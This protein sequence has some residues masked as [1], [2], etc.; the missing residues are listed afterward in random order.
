MVTAKLAI[1]PGR[2]WVVPQSWRVVSAVWR[3]FRVLSRAFAAV[4]VAACAA[5]ATARTDDD[6]L[7]SDAVVRALGDALVSWSARPEARDGLD[8]RYRMT[9]EHATVVGLL[10]GIRGVG[11]ERLELRLGAVEVLTGTGAPGKFDSSIAEL[12]TSG[13]L[14]GV[15]ADRAWT[16]SVDGKDV[17]KAAAD[18][19]SACAPSWSVPAPVPDPTRMPAVRSGGF[20][21]ELEVTETGSKPLAWHR[22]AAESFRLARRACAPDAPA[23]DRDAAKARV[24]P[25]LPL[26]PAGGMALVAWVERAD[27]NQSL[28][29]ASGRI[30]EA[31]AAVASLRGVLERAKLPTL[32]V[33]L[34]ERVPP[35]SEGFRS[36]SSAAC[37]PADA[38]EIM[39]AGPE[40]HRRQERFW[41][42]LSDVVRDSADCSAKLRDNTLAYCSLIIPQ[43]PNN[44]EF[45]AAMRKRVEESIASACA[46]EY[47]EF[48]ALQIAL[49]VWVDAWNRPGALP[50]E[51]VRARDA[52]NAGL[53]DA[54]QSTCLERL[55]I[56]HEKVRTQ[57]DAALAAMFPPLIDA[58]AKSIRDGIAAVHADTSRYLA[59][60]PP[61]P[62]NEEWSQQLLAKIR[63]RILE[64]PL[65]DDHL[66]KELKEYAVPA[67]GD[68]CV[69]AYVQATARYLVQMGIG[70][71]MEITFDVRWSTEYKGEYP[72]PFPFHGGGYSVGEAH[73]H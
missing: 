37:W 70:D 52:W 11:S 28:L 6:V 25:V 22:W 61:D 46:R 38:A 29:R 69:R 42:A 39:A 56:T 36:L 62:A 26:P 4:L 21:V 43:L 35:S 9:S 14:V 51:A 41:S 53:V 2:C 40:A 34:A 30:P 32:T 18:P 8:V 54:L 58:Q 15:R 71:G 49:D 50:A 24:L 19:A 66:I 45:T 33:L 3:H 23:A 72:E 60:F 20:E 68:G 12:S 31:D 55:R 59:A 17:G 63:N 27:A 67:E 7:R 48:Q 5:G 57:C 16:W 1:A 65:N 73:F 13:S 44:A 64:E 10:G 47:P